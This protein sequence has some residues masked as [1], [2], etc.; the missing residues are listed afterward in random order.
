MLTQDE[1]VKT[2][3]LELRQRTLLIAK[4]QIR[5][6][7]LINLQFGVEVGDEVVA[8][9][10]VA[11]TE[12]NHGSFVGRLSPTIFAVGYL[13]SL[14]PDNL[15]AEI[16]G[17]IAK[18]NASQSWP[19]LIQVAVG[20]VVTAIAASQDPTDLLRNA[21]AALAA[22]MRD[23]HAK[24]FQPYL[25]RIEGIR[26]LIGQLA[27][28]LVAPVGM[29]WVLQPVWSIANNELV[30][31]EVL[32]R[33]NSEEFGQL[34][35]E[36]FISIAESLQK[37]NLIDRWSL[38]AAAEACQLLSKE[39]NLSVSSN[40]SSITL[41]LEPDFASFVKGLVEKY[42]LK[43]G[44]LIIELTESSAATN[45]EIIAKF[46]DELQVFGVHVAIDDFGKGLTN[47]AKMASISFQFLKLDI[48]LLR[49]HTIASER[50]ML[51][52]GVE[53]GKVLGVPVLAEGVETRDDLAA[54]LEAGVTL[55]QG[56]LFG[57][58]EPLEY[59]LKSA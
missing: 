20:V 35:P 58:P 44:Q 59:Y 48:G 49:L 12:L 45:S 14:D 42:N 38:E 34:E 8:A 36:T 50:S 9:I 3:E 57:K 19:F 15:I 47:L 13:A 40:I 39:K 30:G 33:W 46:I 28:H 17:A 18:L 31:Y 27:G 55:A 2:L 25:E 7:E 4:I 1:F 11:L 53:V 56:Y 24:I 16:H 37:I 22:S 26:L 10:K 43:P 52:V 6:L 51:R 41:Q 23:G 29:S 32:S 5:E 54:V 21:N